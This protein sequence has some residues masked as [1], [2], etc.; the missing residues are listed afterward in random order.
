LA[1]VAAI[2]AELPERTVS[3]LSASEQRRCEAISAQHRRQQFLAGRWFARQCLARWG[4]GV[5]SDYVL[6]ASD[7]GPPLVLQ[8]PFDLSTRPVHVSVS[9][10]ADGVACAVASHPIGVD[11]EDS[12]RERDIDALGAF[13]HGPREEACLAALNATDRR[14]Q[15]F[16]R[17]SLKEAWLKHQ[18]TSLAMSE[19]ECAPGDPMSAEAVVLHSTE[20]V[21]AVAPVQIGKLRVC[22]E[23]FDG[24]V[25]TP[26]RFLRDR[27]V[28]I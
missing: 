10:S 27:P 23:L 12:A 3:W 22:G 11:V 24:V 13:I 25:A 7:D 18:P 20:W 4:G 5:W 16:A 8:A 17:W 6:S 19:I 28:M 26:W 9:H 2:C 21:V 15:F 1:S 14:H